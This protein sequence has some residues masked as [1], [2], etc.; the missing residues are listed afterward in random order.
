MPGLRLPAFTSAKS[1]LP[2]E[3]RA[4]ATSLPHAVSLRPGAVFYMSAVA[5]AIGVVDAAITAVA[6]KIKLSRTAYK[7]L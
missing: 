4:S 1:V 2:A 6:I 5:V 3:S 7:I